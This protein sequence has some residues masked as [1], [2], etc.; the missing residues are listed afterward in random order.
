MDDVVR[1]GEVE[2]HPSGLEADEE[3]VAMARLELLDLAL[4]FLGRGAAV[5]V[6]VRDALAVE[7]FADQA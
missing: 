2:A 3:Q 5:Q 7:M 4:A 6:S 1:S